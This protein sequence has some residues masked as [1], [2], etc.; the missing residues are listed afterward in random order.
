VHGGEFNDQHYE[1]VNFSIFDILEDMREFLTL[2][3]TVNPSARVILIVSPVPL[4]AIA[5]NRHVLVSTT[6]SKSALR[7]A[8]E[9][10]T[11]EFD[12]TT[13]FSSYEIITGSYTRGRYFAEDLRSVTEDGVEHVMRLFLKYAMQENVTPIAPAPFAESTEFLAQISD[14][15]N[16]I[17]E[18]ELI[19]ASMR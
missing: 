8:C 13:Y 10:I 6:Y 12:W 3:H 4:I 17:C 18:E 15:V 14:I 1:F 5:V 2:L 16:T 9:E 7:T 19:E 11:K